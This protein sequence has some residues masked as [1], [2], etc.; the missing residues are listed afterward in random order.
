DDQQHAQDGHYSDLSA[1]AGSTR[2]ARRAGSQLA[3]MV[4]V[5]PMTLES[6]ANRKSRSSVS[7]VS[8]RPEGSHRIDPRRPQRRDTAGGD[9]NEPEKRGDHR[10]RERIPGADSVELGSDQLRSGERSDGPD[11]DARDH[12]AQRTAQ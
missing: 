8:L 4:S 11:A 6:P 12:R 1:T 7:I 5:R 3:A 9:G 2:V 10:V